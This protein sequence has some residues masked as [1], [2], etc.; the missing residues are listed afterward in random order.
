M[1]CSVNMTG[2]FI[3]IDYVSQINTSR[4]SNLKTHRLPFVCLT[5][6]WIS[7]VLLRAEEQKKDNLVPEQN[8]GL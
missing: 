1:C 7:S 3:L 2:G 6:G 5:G 4:K 8:K